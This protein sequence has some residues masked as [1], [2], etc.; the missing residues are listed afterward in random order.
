MKE[1]RKCK[2]KG[3]ENPSA[4]GKTICWKHSKREY[5]ANV[6]LKKEYEK[7]VQTCSEKNVEPMDF[8]SY[9]DLWK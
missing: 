5:R 9:R 7:Y 3:C 6:K 8:A 1:V 2:Y 4:K